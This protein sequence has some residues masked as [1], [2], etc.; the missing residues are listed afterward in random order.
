M[1][2]KMTSLELTLT[3]SD[4]VARQ[5]EAE[6]LLSAEA[7]VRL[8]ETELDRRQQVQ[9]LFAAADRL[10]ALD[11]SP[12]S[13]AEVEAEIRAVTYSSPTLEEVADEIRSL[14]PNPANVIQPT[15]SLASLLADVAFETPIDS[16]AWNR[17]WAV[18]ES[19][20][21]TRDL[22][23]DRKEGLQFNPL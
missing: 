8:I 21:K 13:D 23:D 15:K 10:A 22:A 1:E 9:D 18:I 4:A 6:G 14:D 5:A 20:M 2:S 16:V 7:V 11:G 19:E 17:Q 12:P 3:F